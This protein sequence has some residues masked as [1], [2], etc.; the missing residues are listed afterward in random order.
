V[1]HNRSFLNQLATT[2][3][4][5]KDGGVLPN[6]GNLDDW[7]YHQRQLAAAAEAQGGAPE[8]GEAGGADA[9]RGPGRDKKRSEAEARNARY[10]LEKPIRQEIERLEA[11]IA[12][13]EAE[14]RVATAALADPAL[15]EDFARAKPYIDRQRLAR[16]ALEG[17]YA[18]WEAAHGRLAE[19]GDQLS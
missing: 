17:L 10:R 2:I 4:E 15:Y 7:L 13:Q 5:V 19:A 14:E 11:E 3:W 18:A 12:A 6:P 1:S 9:A 16:E 8:A